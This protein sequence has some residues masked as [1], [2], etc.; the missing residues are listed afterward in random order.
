MSRCTQQKKGNIF[1]GSLPDRGP[2]SGSVDKV[3]Q[4]NRDNSNTQAY[5]RHYS[6]F[7]S[8]VKPNNPQQIAHALESQV[9]RPS[10]QQ[11]GILSNVGNIFKSVFAPT[12]RRSTVA[13]TSPSSPSSPSSSSYN[14]HPSYNI[15]EQDWPTP[16]IEEP[17]DIDQGSQEETADEPLDQHHVGGHKT[18]HRQTRQHSSKKKTR[19]IRRKKSNLSH[20]KSKNHRR[21]SIK[22]SRSKK[23]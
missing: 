9:N 16:K 20:R 5:S 21:R 2:Y 17:E 8:N 6:S 18:K 19:S 3:C 14:N 4:E 22:K 10:Q 15:Q 23:R 12:P 13:E 7:S 11:Q 1:H